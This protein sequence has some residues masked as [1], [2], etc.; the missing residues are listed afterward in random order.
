MKNFESKEDT[1]GHPI[2]LR[3][4]EGR[5]E[6][7]IT[8]QTVAI[9]LAAI[10]TATLAAVLFYL[11]K[12]HVPLN[13]DFLPA[14]VSLMQLQ[15]T[16]YQ[17]KFYIASV[18]VLATLCIVLMK[19]WCRPEQ[20]TKQQTFISF[21]ILSL[22]PIFIFSDWTLNNYAGY[23]LI[24][25]IVCLLPLISRNQDSEGFNLLGALVRCV[26]SRPLILTALF[27]LVLVMWVLPIAKPLE[28]YSLVDLTWIDEHYSFT[29][30]GGYDLTQVDTAYQMRQ[31]AYG[32][33]MPILTAAFLQATSVLGDSLLTLP[34]AVKFYQ[35][36]AAVLIGLIFFVRE[37]KGWPIWTLMTLLA[38]AFTLS[39]VGNAIGYPNQSG[40]RFVPM[41][42]GI[43]FVAMETKRADFRVE[44]LAVAIAVILLMNMETGMAVLV[45]TMAVLFFRS[46]AELQS[47]IKAFVP[48]VKFLCIHLAAL[49]LMG[50]VLLPRLIPDTA[51]LTDFVTLFG[52]SGYGGMKSKLSLTACIVILVSAFTLIDNA[53]RVKNGALGENDLWEVFLATV[54]LIWMTYYMNRMAEW[55]LWLQWVLLSFWF[56]SKFSK[57]DFLSHRGERGFNDGLAPNLLI[58]LLL[59]AISGQV[60]TSVSD[61]VFPE[62]KAV[63]KSAVKKV[64]GWPKREMSA[65]EVSGFKIYGSAGEA[66]QKHFAELKSFDKDN[67]QVLSKCPTITRLHG[68]NGRSMIYSPIEFTTYSDLPR[69][70]ELI[71]ASPCDLVAFDHPES[72]IALVS[73]ET[74]VQLKSLFGDTLSISSDKVGDWS[75]VSK[76]DLL[77]SVSR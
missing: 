26:K 5:S 58:V 31:A 27:L 13:P 48:L 43:L 4:G 74:A 3:R 29:V 11:N 35:F 63:A 53:Y 66:V 42:V 17:K 64:I 50:S 41:L 32:L 16:E 36:V 28:I 10:F 77:N 44:V 45:G 37:R 7:S 76:Q 40:I 59:A 51:S 18:L 21:A 62:F 30:L 38:T 71:A 52:V 70:K 24:A 47:L 15:S 56:S 9:A 60:L 34:V 25:L 2:E 12:V 8:S 65:Y 54:M 68:F 55:N 46:F 57:F 67:V 1:L 49:L 6:S 20:I 61:K 14:H 23:G 73:K 19:G 22:F 72:D 39:N 75:V 69:M 33:G